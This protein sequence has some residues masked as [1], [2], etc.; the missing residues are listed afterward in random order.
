MSKSKEDEANVEQQLLDQH[1]VSLPVMAPTAAAGAA[2]L[3]DLQ[4]SPIAMTSN[5]TRDHNFLD[6]NAMQD[7]ELT[8]LSSLGRRRRVRLEFVDRAGDTD[9]PPQWAPVEVPPENPDQSWENERP[10]L[11][12]LP[13]TALLRVLDAKSGKVVT[14][15]AGDQ[16]LNVTR[17]AAT[18]TLPRALCMSR[19]ERV[20]AL[21]DQVEHTSLP[22]SSESASAL[23]FAV[24]VLRHKVPRQPVDHALPH[25]ESWTF[26]AASP[27]AATAWIG[28]VRQAV[29]WRVTT[30]SGHATSI[31]KSLVIDNY[32]CAFLA[33]GDGIVHEF[34]NGLLSR[35]DWGRARLLPLA[36]IAGGTGNGL[37]VS[38]NLIS[39]AMTVLAAIKGWAR[40]FDMMSIYQDRESPQGTLVPH[41]LGISHL[42]VTT[43]YVADFDIESEVLRVL[44]HLRTEIWALLRMLVPKYYGY[45]LAYVLDKDAEQAAAT[46]AHAAKT[47]PD[48]MHV[49]EVGPPPRLATVPW[50]A[51]AAPGSGWTVLP[52]NRYFLVNVQNLSHLGPDFN[53]IPYARMHDGLLDVMWAGANVKPLSLLPYFLDSTT[54]EHVLHPRIHHA[55]ARAVALIPIHPSDPDFDAHFSTAAAGSSG[56]DAAGVDAPLLAAGGRTAAAGIARSDPAWG[57]TQRTGHMVIDGEPVPYGAV[58]IEVHAALATVICARDLD[59]EAFARHVRK[60]AASTNQ[61]SRPGQ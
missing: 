40:P 6:M 45:R 31:A 42:S 3:D 35:P 13:M 11:R 38:L 16:V 26:A 46:A 53:C 2:V 49:P 21:M 1:A 23:R 48:Q 19:L 27:A 37:A 30:G 36:H 7:G 55:K 44:G 4:A 34:W 51:L 59:E 14:E 60:D 28:R 32:H 24:H 8:L 61:A 58:R 57:K 33:G 56:G 18:V 17:A 5:G 47:T 15:I 50:A 39:P 9:Q 29:G 20:V 12:H 52:A 54:G 10:P 22:T 41:R 25:F 43:A